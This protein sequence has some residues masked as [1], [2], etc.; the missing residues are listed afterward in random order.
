MGGL[1]LLPVLLLLSEP[2]PDNI[3]AVAK[4]T[5][6][7]LNFVIFSPHERQAVATTLSFLCMKNERAKT[8]PE[9]SVIVN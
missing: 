9:K 5:T 4:A 6:L 3:T 2:H 1:L 7:N 8:K